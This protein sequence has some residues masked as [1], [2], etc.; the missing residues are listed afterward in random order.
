[1]STPLIHFLVPFVVLLVLFKKDKYVYWLSPFA[2]LPDIDSF[3]GY[4]RAL[5]HNIFVALALALLMFV[6]LNNNKVFYIV[7][8][9]MASHIILDTFTGGVSIFYPVYS[10]MIYVNSGIEIDSYRHLSFIF[11]YG[12]K[13]GS[14]S[15]WENAYGD[16]VSGMDSAILFILGCCYLVRRKI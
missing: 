2:L 10:N 14:G 13:R 3:T 12:I 5:L 16:V 11:D 6:V 9:Y 7:F 4:H 1:M 8:I 15:M